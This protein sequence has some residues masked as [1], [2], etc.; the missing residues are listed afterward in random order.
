MAWICA[1]FVWE[2]LFEDF[3][4]AFPTVLYSLQKNIIIQ[5]LSGNIR[6]TNYD[7]INHKIT[8]WIFLV[9]IQFTKRK[10]CQIEMLLI[11]KLWLV[12]GR[13]MMNSI[14]KSV[15]HLKAAKSAFYNRTLT[16]TIAFHFYSIQTNKTY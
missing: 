16:F 5:F 9:K 2:N 4:N 6:D 10:Y 14:V 13:W 12:Q 3:H 7:E 1:Q 15:T 8:N 11:I